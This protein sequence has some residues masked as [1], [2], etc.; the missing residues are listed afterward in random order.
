MKTKRLFLLLA[1]ML[2]SLGALAQSP[3]K[4]D[5][6]NDGKVDVADIA[7]IIEIMKN[8]GGIGGETLY[9]WYA[10]PDM[11]TS[12][13]VP[14]TNVENECSYGWHYIIGNPT[15]IET[16]ELGTSDCPKINWVLAVPT[17]FGLTRISNGEDIT[18]IYDVSTVTTAD[19]VEYIVFKQIDPS[20][21]MDVTFVKGSNDEA[22]YYWYAGTT[23]PTA[24]NIAS[25]ALGSSDEIEYWD[26]K[27]FSITNTGEES[28]P[29][30]VCTPVDFKVS[31]TDMNGFTLNLVEVEG[32]GFS[33]NGIEYKVQRRGRELSAGATI[34]FRGYYTE[35]TTSND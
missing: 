7:A 4:G 23:L 32:A 8:G 15:S 19:G 20:K 14:G 10:G 25:I 6:N 9:Y 2:M 3:L 30:Y 11:L 13:T 29:A 31:W 17:K 18:D 1:M 26:G 34:T 27:V 5:V 21:K 12:E 35:T 16:G 33:L 24:E 28:T 22:K